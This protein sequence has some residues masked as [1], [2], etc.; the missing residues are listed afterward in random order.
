MLHME[1]IPYIL[2]VLL[3]SGLAWL[4]TS[5][6]ANWNIEHYCR[7]CEDAAEIRDSEFSAKTAI[8]LIALW[9]LAAFVSGLLYG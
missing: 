1:Y 6:V 2:F 5:I 8:V 4:V 3:G 7:R 9:L